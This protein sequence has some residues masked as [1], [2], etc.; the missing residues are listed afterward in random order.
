MPPGVDRPDLAQRSI[1]ADVAADGKGCPAGGAALRVTRGRQ[2]RLVVDRKALAAQRQGWLWDWTAEA[3]SQGC[4]ASGEGLRLAARIVESVPLDSRDASR[5]LRA[6]ASRSSVE[7]GPASRIQAVTPIVRDGAAPDAPL[8]ETVGISGD[9]A[10]LNVAVKAS[11]NLVGVETAWYSVVAKN[12]GSGF[13][14]LPLSAERSIQGNTETAASP[15]VNYL[16]FP[17]EANYYRLFFK[18]DSQGGGTNTMVIAAPTRAELNRRTRAIDADPKLCGAPD[19]L[20]VAIPRRSAINIWTAVWVNGKEVRVRGGSIRN[21]IEEA[22]ERD[23]SR[24]LPRLRVER[25]YGG[26]LARVE[27]DAAGTDILN[28]VLVGGERISW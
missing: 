22:G 26:R 1:R 4:I 23:V 6:G 5:L 2:A 27:F 17:A 7:I 13:T 18:A 12:G 15:L 24:V 28:L 21:A 3:E 20:C 19:G 11:E 9:G 25:P 8:V 16:R 14:F 10:A